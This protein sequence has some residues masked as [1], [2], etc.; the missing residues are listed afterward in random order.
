MEIE[1]G[2]SVSSA[3]HVT[4]KVRALATGDPMFILGSWHQLR[5]LADHCW[6]RRLATLTHCI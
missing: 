6:D 3:R 4:R 5:P 2:A 1:D